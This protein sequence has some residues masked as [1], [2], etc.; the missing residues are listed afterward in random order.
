VYA[1][2]RQQAM[3]QLVREHGRMS[4]VELAQRYDVTTET[5]RRDLSIL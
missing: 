1:A 2:E 4:V 3:T 5:V